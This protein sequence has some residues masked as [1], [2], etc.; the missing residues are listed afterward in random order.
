MKLLDQHFGEVSGGYKLYTQFRSSMQDFKESS[1]EFKK[2]HLL[3]LK[4]VERGG[5]NK[6]D[7]D[8]EVLR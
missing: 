1:S 5:V 6:I 7:V 4:T 8:L 2:I 3:A